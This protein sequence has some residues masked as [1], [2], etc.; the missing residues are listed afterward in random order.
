MCFDGH[1]TSG[2]RV[3]R[4]AKDERVTE[5][6]RM[7]ERPKEEM[8]VLSHCTQDEAETRERITLLKFTP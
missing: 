1:S 8:A 3:E 5:R 7:Q 2:N 6:N 4:S